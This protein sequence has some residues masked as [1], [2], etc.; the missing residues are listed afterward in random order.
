MTKELLS[1]MARVY[2]LSGIEPDMWQGQQTYWVDKKDDIG[3][4]PRLSNIFVDKHKFIECEDSYFQQELTQPWYSESQLWDMLPDGAYYLEGKFTFEKGNGYNEIFF[5][6]DS[7]TNLHTAL[8]EMVL[9][10]LEQGYIKRREM[11]ED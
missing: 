4:E 10:C 9:Y 11:N 5:D 1:S 3:Q 8:V 6:P 7:F 2:E